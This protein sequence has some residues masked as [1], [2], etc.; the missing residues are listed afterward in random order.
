MFLKKVSRKHTLLLMIYYL[1]AY[2]GYC[3][4]GERGCRLSYVDV[5]ASSLGSGPAY[6]QNSLGNPEN[7]YVGIINLEHDSSHTWGL[8]SL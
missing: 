8:T 5:W 2:L 7:K 6:T 4:V 3:S 1:F